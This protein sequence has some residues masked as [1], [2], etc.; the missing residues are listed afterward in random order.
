MNRTITIMILIMLALAGCQAETSNEVVIGVSLSLTGSLSFMGESGQMAMEMALEEIQ[1]ENPDINFRLVF[2]DDGF[3][4]TTAVT[5]AR[6]L[7]D[8]EGADVI[9]SFG[10]PTGTVIGPIAQEAGIIH[11]GI[12]SANVAGIGNLNFNQ[13]TPPSAQAE[14]L[15]ERLLEDGISNVGV[16]TLNHAG[17]MMVRDEVFAS[18]AQAGITVTLEERFEPGT[19]DFRTIWQKIANSDPEVVFF[20]ALT[21]EFELLLRQRI[22]LGIEI[23]VVTIESPDYSDQPELFDG[24]WFVNAAEPTE[25]FIEQ[26]ESRFG[27]S[28][29]VFSANAFD[30]VQLV[31]WAFAQN[32][33]DATAEEIAQTLLTVENWPSAVGPIT[34]DEEGTFVSEAVIREMVDGVSVT[35]E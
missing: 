20:V 28:P 15:V 9:V 33:A 8:V 5:T 4:P 6:R 25:E 10:S 14:R 18:F 12:A 30:I 3:R 16:I 31:G 34:A 32:G 23:P 26:F 11:V 17:G 35:V 7:I 21:P 29:R 24:N 22:E 19:T 27:S 2:E 1:A 13:W